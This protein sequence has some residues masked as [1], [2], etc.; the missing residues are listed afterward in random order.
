VHSSYFK[1]SQITIDNAHINNRLGDYYLALVGEL[2]ARLRSDDSDAV[3]WA[4]LGNALSQF[5]NDPLLKGAL[6]NGISR[7]QALLYAATAYYCGGFP[8]SAY[9]TI[10]GLHSKPLDSEYARA[11]YDLL[12]RPQEATSTTVSALR[13]AVRSGNS[14]A[15]VQIQQSIAADEAAALTIGPQEWIQAR[16]LHKLVDRFLIANLRSALP[17]GDHSFWTP[18]VESF[19]SRTPSTW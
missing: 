3:S 18:L 13:S 14:F 17:G 7:Q 15:L 5:G 8:A 11:C 19:V 2:F 6:E 4:R 1:A 10:G 12:A 9:L 16:L